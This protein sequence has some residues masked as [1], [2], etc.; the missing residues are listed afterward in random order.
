MKQEKQKINSNEYRQ[1]DYCPRQWYLRQT[2]GRRNGN[3]S[4]RR[5]GMKYH[6]NMAHGIKSVQI[7]QSRFRT[8]AIITGGV[9]CLFLLVS[10]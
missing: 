5:R 10:L 2:L 8:A 9:I 1:W 7:A 4:A 3:N 6:Q